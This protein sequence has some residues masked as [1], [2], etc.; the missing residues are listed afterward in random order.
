VYADGEMVDR[1]LRIEAH[2]MRQLR[3]I[4]DELERL[5]GADVD[6]VGGLGVGVV[7]VEGLGVGCSIPRAV[8][9]VGT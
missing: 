2:L 4:L 9:T 8:S 1:V 7:G 6:G 5:R 3:L